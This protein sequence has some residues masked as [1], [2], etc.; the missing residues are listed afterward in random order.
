[1]YMRLSLPWS[2]RHR[3]TFLDLWSETICAQTGWISSARLLSGLLV[4]FCSVIPVCSSCLRHT[5][6]VW[7]HR[8]MLRNLGLCT[9]STAHPLLL[10]LPA[11]SFPMV[12]VPV[13]FTFISDE[14]ESNAVVVDIDIL[15]FVFPTASA[16]LGFGSKNGMMVQSQCERHSGLFMK[17][18]LTTDSAG[19]AF[20]PLI[21]FALA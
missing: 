1:M 15:Y 11:P 20:M 18:S 9:L 12:T 8:C 6:Q 17:P 21:Q 13:W 2:C 14:M 19:A 10:N 4:G 5:E 3:H 16:H 7:V